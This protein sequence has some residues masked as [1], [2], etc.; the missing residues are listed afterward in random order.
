LEENLNWEFGAK[1]AHVTYHPVTLDTSNITDDMEKI[2]NALVKADLNVLFTYAN[3]DDNGRRINQMIEEFCNTNPTKY[4]VEKNLGQ[5]RY[6]SAMKYVNVLIGNTS[7][8]II[9]AAS[10]QKPVV[11]IGDRQKGRL[12]SSNVLDCTLQTLQK[13]IQKACSREFK[14]HCKMTTNIYGNGKSSEKIVDILSTIE[15]S[16]VKKFVDMDI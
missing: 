12:Q 9:E 16:V 10:F 11:N 3:A 2:L 15:L 6:L 13:T 1:S 14:D 7:S 4:R 8:G 5:L